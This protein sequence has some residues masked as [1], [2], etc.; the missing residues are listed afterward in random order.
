M[1]LDRVQSHFPVV[2]AQLDQ[3]LRQADRVL[4]VDVGVDQ[5]VQDQQRPL[6]VLGEVDRR[7]SVVGL[8]IVLRRVEDVAGVPVVVVGPVGD[9]RANG[10]RRR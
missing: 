7:R 9:R 8:G 10:P 4:G 3:P 6:E 2:L 5:A 1:V